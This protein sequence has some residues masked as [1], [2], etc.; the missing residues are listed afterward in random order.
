MFIMR[1][2]AQPTLAQNKRCYKIIRLFHRYSLSV[3]RVPGAQVTLRVCGA[4]KTEKDPA[5]E[6]S[7]AGLGYGTHGA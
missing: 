7:L 1:L 4:T 5:F 2:S 3:C 6:G